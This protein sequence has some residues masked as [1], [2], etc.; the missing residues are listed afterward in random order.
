MQ[1]AAKQKRCRGGCG[2][3]LPLSDYYTLGTKYFQSQCKSCAKSYRKFWASKYPARAAF[4]KWLEKQ[5]L[6]EA[7]LAVLGGCCVV[8]GNADK[9]VLQ[10]DHV[11]GDR[12]QDSPNPQT[13]YRNVK[14]N[15][16]RYQLLC[17]NCHS[18]KTFEN[19]ETPQ[20]KNLYAIAY[21]KQQDS[22]IPR[23]L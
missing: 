13:R 21:K 11:A 7:A 8:C 23:Q 6:R 3:T 15:P 16:A 17:A 22:Y 4:H 12:K 10:I 9:R 5:K 2:R 18:I 19:K 20:T 14:R 1:V